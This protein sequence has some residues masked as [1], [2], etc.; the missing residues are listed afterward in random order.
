M[1][2][3]FAAVILALIVAFYLL[4]HEN[5]R[6]KQYHH[7]EILNLYKIIEDLQNA[8]NKQNSIV[9]ICD[10]LNKKLYNSRGEIDKKMLNLQRELIDK[11]VN[12][13]L[14]DT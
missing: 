10:E 3:F 7:L 14:I 11:L 9:Q 5:K 2:I 6:I 8:Q 12:N 13:G 4:F 1:N